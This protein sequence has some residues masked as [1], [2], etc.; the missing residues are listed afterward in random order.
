MLS[1]ITDILFSWDKTSLL[2][3]CILADYI[4]NAISPWNEQNCVEFFSLFWIAYITALQP[5]VVLI[6]ELRLTCVYSGFAFKIHIVPFSVLYNNT[7]N[8]LSFVKKKTPLISFLL[9]GL[10][11]LVILLFLFVPSWKASR[12]KHISWLSYERL[13]DLVTH[14]LTLIIP[15]LYYREN[16]G[17]VEPS[18][19]LK[20]F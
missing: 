8:S 4:E 18:H 10:K 20:L 9:K 12:S 13:L 1:G 16:F 15:R 7:E 6:T 14:N 11:M 5:F 2:T 17:C 3:G 19:R